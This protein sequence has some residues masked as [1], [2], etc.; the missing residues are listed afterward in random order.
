MRGCADWIEKASGDFGEEA[1]LVGGYCLIHHVSRTLSEFLGALRE[2]N[3]R[4]MIVLMIEFPSTGEVPEFSVTV[5]SSEA[6]H[7]LI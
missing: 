4:T 7:I 1:T 3:S 2:M 6:Q 5:S